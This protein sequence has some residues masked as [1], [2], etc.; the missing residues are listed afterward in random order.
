MP[1]SSRCLRRKEEM[2]VGVKGDGGHE[3]NMVI[4]SPKQG[5]YSLTESEEASTRPA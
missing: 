5:S 3:E 2:I 1:S 4:Q